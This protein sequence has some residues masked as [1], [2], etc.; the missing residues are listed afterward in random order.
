LVSVTN[1]RGRIPRTGVTSLPRTA[2]EFADYFKKS[3]QGRANKTDIE[4][5]YSE[6]VGQP[7]RASAYMEGAKDEHAKGFKKER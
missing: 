3:E 6:F 7:N 2:A 5:Y 1:P 4:A